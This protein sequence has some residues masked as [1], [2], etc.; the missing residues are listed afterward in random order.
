VVECDVGGCGCY[1]C[2]VGVYDLVVV[3]VFGCVEVVVGC[4][5]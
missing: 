5:E 4:V 2:G 1:W 3:G